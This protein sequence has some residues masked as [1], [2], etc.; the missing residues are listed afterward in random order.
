MQWGQRWDLPD[1][2]DPEKLTS[3]SLDQHLNIAPGRKLWQRERRPQLPG[4][5]AHG[6]NLFPPLGTPDRGQG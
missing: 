4:T 5:G 3:F 2:Q 1:K 6:A